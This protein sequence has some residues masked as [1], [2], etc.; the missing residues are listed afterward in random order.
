MRT[1]WLIWF[2]NQKT[3]NHALSVVHRHCHIHGVYTPPSHR[4]RHR[5]LYGYAIVNDLVNAY[6]IFSISDF[7]FQM[8]AI[9]V[10]FFDLQ[11]CLYNR[12]LEILHVACDK[13]CIVRK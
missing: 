13:V 6:Q 9:L 5:N 3:Y 2:I 12:Q 8:A 11:T 4:V 7:C 10:R 1:V